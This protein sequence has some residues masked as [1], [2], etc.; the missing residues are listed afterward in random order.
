MNLKYFFKLILLVLVIACASDDKPEGKTEAEVL[1]KEAKELMDDGRYIM[2]TERLNQIKSQYPYSYYS[3]YAELMLADVLYKQESYVEASAAYI[4][5]RDFHP[6]Y[7]ELDYVIYKIGESFFKQI[8]DTF[9]RDLTSA[10]EAIRYFDELLLKYPGSKYEE[11]VKKKINE[12][13]KMIK[14]KEKYI[15]DFYY[16][17]KVYGAARYRYLKI[18]REF[19]D[20]ELLQHSMSRIIQSS[21]RLGEIDECNNYAKKYF[22]LLD[23]KEKNK[24]RKIVTNCLKN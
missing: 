7:K 5:F 24:I 12:A 18:L 8:P 1:Y 23:N 11:E 13:N 16:K 15:A 4:V 6:K 21:F 14:N 20:N 3:T 19:D 2:A 22:D 17:T 10:H 9:D